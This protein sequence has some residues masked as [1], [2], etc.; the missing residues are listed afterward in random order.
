MKVGDLL[1]K[2]LLVAV[3]LIILVVASLFLYTIFAF[4]AKPEI[5]MQQKIKDELSCTPSIFTDDWNVW[6]RTFRDSGGN[7]T[8]ID[9]WEQF[10][11]NYRQCIKPTTIGIDDGHCVVWFKNSSNQA[12]YYEY[13]FM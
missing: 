10:K 9:S 5:N 1:R 2:G 4:L 3:T 8:K 11:E 7:L 12:T 6:S 13:L